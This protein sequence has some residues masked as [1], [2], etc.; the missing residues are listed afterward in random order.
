MKAVFKRVADSESTLLD[1]LVFKEPKTQPEGQ[2]TLEVDALETCLGELLSARR[3]LFLLLFLLIAEIL[4]GIDKIKT[5]E[6]TELMNLHSGEFFKTM[7]SEMKAYYRVFVIDNLLMTTLW[8]VI[9]PLLRSSEDSE[10]MRNT[11]K[12][13]VPLMRKLKDMVEA[14]E[15]EPETVK[16]IVESFWADLQKRGVVH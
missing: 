11:M 1:M 10:A 16:A 5:A 14:K 6:L 15:R 13:F 7:L 9:F 4:K 3:E 8:Q 2:I 12:S